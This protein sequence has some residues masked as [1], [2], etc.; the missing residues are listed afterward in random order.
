MN[1]ELEEIARMT[2]G[3]NRAITRFCSISSASMKLDG[4]S[5]RRTEAITRDRPSSFSTSRITE[6][7][8]APGS[9]MTATSVMIPGRPTSSLRVL[10]AH[11]QDRELARARAATPFSG[12]A[13]MYSGLAAIPTTRT[14]LCCLARSAG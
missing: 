4:W 12:T 2:A 1:R 8:S 11:E 6:S 3:R 9:A 5:A 10:G 14:C 7:T 13:Y